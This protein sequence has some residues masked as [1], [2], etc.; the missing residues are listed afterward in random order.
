MPY[1][2]LLIALLAGHSSLAQ[3]FVD[4]GPVFSE[5]VETELKK[6]D[7]L[8]EYVRTKWETDV[9]AY[10]TKLFIAPIKAVY[11]RKIISNKPEFEVDGTITIEWKD[12][13]YRYLFHPDSYVPYAKDR[14]GKIAPVSK[15]A[16]DV[17]YFYEERFDKKSS[18]LR[19]RSQIEEAVQRV[20]NQLTSYISSGTYLEKKRAEQSKEVV[21][22][23]VW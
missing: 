6:P 13:K 4:K 12:E 2:L 11:T 23:P 7:Q 9:V 10:P 21:Q 14:Y 1:L 5:I 20:F 16:K 18:I 19:T 22:K 8:A 17:S 15:K 3:L